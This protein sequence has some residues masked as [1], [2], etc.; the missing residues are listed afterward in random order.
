MKRGVPPGWGA[1]LAENGWWVGQKRDALNLVQIG[2]KMNA[3][4]SSNG[5]RELVK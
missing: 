1:G 4:A 3:V 5:V 2:L